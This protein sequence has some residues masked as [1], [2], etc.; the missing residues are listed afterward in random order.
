MWQLHIVLGLPHLLASTAFVL[1][2][3][4]FHL[5]AGQFQAAYLHVQPKIPIPGADQDWTLPPIP[6]STLHLIFNS[7]GGLLHRWPNTLRRNG[8]TLRSAPIF[9][10]LRYVAS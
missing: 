2:S 7:V 8:T 1:P 10:I 9:P 4:P 5:G 6:N 3:E